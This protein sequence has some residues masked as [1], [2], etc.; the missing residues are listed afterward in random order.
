MNNCKLLTNDGTTDIQCNKTECKIKCNGIDY[1]ISYN[2][3]I[4][5]C[6]ANVDKQNH[7][8]KSNHVRIRREHMTAHQRSMYEKRI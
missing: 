5:C 8:K 4:K 7:F 6:S 1:V 2:D 3:F